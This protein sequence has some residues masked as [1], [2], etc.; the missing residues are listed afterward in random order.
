MSNH[1]QCVAENVIDITASPYHNRTKDSGCN[2]HHFDSIR[3]TLE[4]ENGNGDIAGAYSQALR[5][6]PSPLVEARVP[7]TSIL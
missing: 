3:V 5:L 4:L 1:A 7:E 2:L 6:G